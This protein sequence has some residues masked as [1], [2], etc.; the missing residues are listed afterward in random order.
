M[1]LQNKIVLLDLALY[2]C[3]IVYKL[4]FPDTDIYLISY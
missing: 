3:E 1:L 2:L 4:H